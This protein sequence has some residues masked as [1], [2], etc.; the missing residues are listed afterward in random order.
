MDI[1]NIA[2]KTEETQVLFAQL[3]LKRTFWS[4]VVLKRLLARLNPMKKINNSSVYVTMY[5][6]VSSK[7]RILKTAT[8]GH[9][10]SWCVFFFFFFFFF[11]IGY[12]KKLMRS[13]FGTCGG[14]WESND[15]LIQLLIML[16]SWIRSL[17]VI[18]VSN[19][20]STKVLL[21]GGHR[22]DLQNLRSKP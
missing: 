6:P 21:K 7:T 22:S 8:H 1:R 18:L 9:A 12:G 2:L 14:A 10:V 17:P 16:L 15:Y 13:L 5:V 3:A 19:N 20:P 11:F 4:M